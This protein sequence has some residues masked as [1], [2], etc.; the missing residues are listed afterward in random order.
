MKPRDAAIR[1]HL[2]DWSVEIPEGWEHELEE[3][4]LS[5]HDPTGDGVL[6]FSAVTKT[7][8]GNVSDA[9][10]DE[11]VDDLGLAG[12]PAFP[13]RYGAFTGLHLYSEGEGEAAHQHWLLRHRALLLV[14]VYS[15]DEADNGNEDVAIAG[16]LGSLRSEEAA[17]ETPTRQ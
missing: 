14:V 1:I 16:T 15:C 13:A 5:M 11:F 6:T 2:G 12:V 9:D 17:P 4:V 10:L 7:E 8:G 3:N